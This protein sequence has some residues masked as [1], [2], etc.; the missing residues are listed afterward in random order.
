[1]EE[2]K[3]W[4]GL[5]FVPG[6]G[7]VGYKSLI[8]RFQNPKAVFEASAKELDQVEGIGGKTA[9]AIKNFSDWESV[10]SAIENL[11][12]LGFKLVSITDK[13]YPKN[14][15]KIYYPPSILYFHGEIFP[16]DELALAVVGTRAADRYGRVVTET[17]SSELASMGIT[18]VSGMARGIDSVAHAAALKSGGRT[19]AVLGSGLDVIY[20]PENKNLYNQISENGA[21]ISEFPLGSEPDAVNF[22]KRNRIIS[23]LSLGVLV[24][25]ASERSGSL[26]TASFALEQNREVFAVPGNVASKLSRGTN[27]L[28]KK[29]AK[30]V[31]SIED[32]LGEVDSFRRLK[33]IESPVDISSIL[34]RLNGD[35]KRIFSTITNEP[36]HIDDIITQSGFE[37]HRVLSTLLSLELEG[38]ITQLPGK[39]FQLR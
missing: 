21:V 35:G 1:M 36:I 25:Q 16:S 19:I 26:I 20:P 28:I 4:L 18:I 14:L 31:D 12:R 11:R 30:L 2:W 37:P 13:D 17:L 9:E 24:I 5:S 33:P 38:F 39:M 7:D 29:G 3:Y 32:I 23:G 34:E 27:A 6:V 8:S 22:P 15:S 10:N